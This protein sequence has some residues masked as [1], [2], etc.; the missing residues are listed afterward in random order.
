MPPRHDVGF[1]C[2]AT[3]R[4]HFLEIKSLKLLDFFACHSKRIMEHTYVAFSSSFRSFGVVGGD[5]AL[6]KAP[7]VLISVG[8]EIS[9]HLN[10]C[11]E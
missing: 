4:P 3:G 7:P 8:D 10:I 6:P 5:D 1:T 9:R 11:Q 2:A